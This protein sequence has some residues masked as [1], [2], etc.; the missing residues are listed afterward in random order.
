[1]E[2]PQKAAAETE[3][4]RF[5]GFRFIYQRGIIQLQFFQRFFKIGIILTFSR[6]YAGIDHWFGLAVAWQ[7]VFRRVNSVGNRIANPAFRHG[8]EPGSDIT[9][10][11]RFEFINRKEVRRENANFDRLNA[12]SIRHH[13]NFIPAGQMAVENAHI[14]NDAFIRII[15]GVKNQRAQ[16]SVDIPR[17]RRD[18]LGNRFQ[19]QLDVQAGFRADGNNFVPGHSQEVSEVLFD[20]L[21]LRAG[22]VNLVDYRNDDQVGV[23]G[24]VKVGERLGFD[25]LGGIHHQ[26]RAFAS[27]QRAADFIVKIHVPRGINQVEFVILGVAAVVNHPDRGGFDGN[28]FFP[29]QIHGIEHLLGHIAV[30]NSAGKL[31]HPIRQSG[32][33]VIYMRDDTKIADFFHRRIEYNR[34]L[35]LISEGI[36]RAIASSVSRQSPP[37]PN[38][39]HNKNSLFPSEPLIGEVISPAGT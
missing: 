13:H 32:F 7:R 12:D 33:A 4:Q 22:Q 14:S 10:V 28:A 26:H 5:A 30:R 23:Q 38:R 35:Q 37:Q 24:K 36:T 1:V 39:S 19:Y 17:R 21:H 18:F 9:N 8:F 2:Q 29:L 16:R 25:A 20:R 15:V 3:V 27:I 31:Q 6:V 34:F 11:T